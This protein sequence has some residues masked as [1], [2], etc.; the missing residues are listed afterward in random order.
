MR[1]R[2]SILTLSAVATLLLAATASAQ[3]PRQRHFKFTYAFSVRTPERG[4]P[5]KVW[6]PIATSDRWQKVQVL[7]A[8]GDLPLKKTREAEYGDN[9]YYA[10]T[11]KAARDEYHF[12]VVYDVVRTERIGLQDGKPMGGGPKLQ[13]A[14]MNRFL[15]PDK[16]VPITGL[17]ADLAQQETKGMSEP[18][19]K[20]HAIYDYVFRTMRYDK[21]GTGWGRGDTMWACDAKRGNCTDF[22]S[23][24]ASMARSQ[25][26]PV[27]FAIGFPLPAAKHSGQI[28]G[29][30]CWAD[31]YAD[32]A[33]VPVDISEAWKDQS[34]KD[35]YFGRHDENRV[36]FSVGRDIRLN[37][38]QAGEPVNYFVYPYVESDGKVHQNVSNDFSFE[39]VG[40]TS[41]AELK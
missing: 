2:I 29:Y 3:A 15:E 24:F 34:K 17:P 27:R 25:N 35:Y 21:S 39:D 1:S 31:F 23:L 26:I 11:S 36:Q 10:T 5:L 20:A 9:M 18:L 33:W 40:A 14:S 8:K 38:P 37:P 7:S 16:L 19:Q 4:K 13:R 30:H 41:Q 12:E 22:H 32:Q 28:P 6:F